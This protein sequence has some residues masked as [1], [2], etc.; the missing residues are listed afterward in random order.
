MNSKGMVSRWVLLLVCV[1]PHSPYRSLAAAN[2][3]GIS[4]KSFKALNPTNQIPADVRDEPAFQAAR[5]ELL[6]KGWAPNLT[7]GWRASPPASQAET[8]VLQVEGPPSRLFGSI[9][10]QE[11][12][13]LQDR[14]LPLQQI[15]KEN[16]P[17][18]K[19]DLYNQKYASSAN[20]RQSQSWMIYTRHPEAAQAF[21]VE[22]LL[23]ALDEYPVMVITQFG[24]GKLVL[25]LEHEIFYSIDPPDSRA[26]SIGSV[27]DCLK[28]A[29]GL[30]AAYS[31]SE[32][33]R[34]FCTVGDNVKTAVFFAINCA[35]CVTLSGC[36]D[37][38]LTLALFLNCFGLNVGECLQARGATPPDALDQQAQRDMSNRAAVDSRFFS[39]Q[40]DSFKKNLN[41]DSNWQLRW[42]NFLFS[43]SNFEGYVTI[44]HATSKSNPG[45]RYTT[46]FDPQQNA[47]RSWELVR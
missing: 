11:P 47:W 44:Y 34:T 2:E 18:V 20:V 46:F 13:E 19:A 42:V 27:W 26:L 17:R 32:A 8:F 38:I 23:F 41:W 6:G 37:C 9:E 29:F 4:F 3:C 43:G 12:V 22:S 10:L 1:F 21:L 7:K 39:L 28:Q 40:P 16:P 45:L 5:D 33:I 30:P 31:L 36:A 14:I 24:G 25:N 15:R 35:D